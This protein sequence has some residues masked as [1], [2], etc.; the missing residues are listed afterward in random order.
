MY[1]S[2]LFGACGRARACES[3]L[4]SVSKFPYKF[5]SVH[6]IPAT[7]GSLREI[8]ERLGQGRLVRP[9]LC[10][11][12]RHE[13]SDAPIARPPFRLAL[14]P[15]ITVDEFPEFSCQSFRYHNGLQAI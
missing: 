2:K 11:P 3:W 10:D 4:V 6:T 15:D 8:L 12:R 14:N 7:A 13:F 1:R 9:I 5:V